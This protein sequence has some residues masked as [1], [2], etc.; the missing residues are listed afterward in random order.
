MWGGEGSLRN[1]PTPFHLLRSLM[2]IS[3]TDDF[4]L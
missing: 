4:E 1:R 2:H 3:T